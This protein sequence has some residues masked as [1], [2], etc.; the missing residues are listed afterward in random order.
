M[1]LAF[2]LG[3][4]GNELHPADRAI[5]GLILN[6]LWVHAAGV[7]RFLGG[8]DLGRPGAGRHEKAESKQNK[9]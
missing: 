7:E 1:R 2:R 5:T 9:K 6:H 4:F 3:F 8:S